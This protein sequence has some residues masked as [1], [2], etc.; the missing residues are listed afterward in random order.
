MNPDNANQVK[1]AVDLAVS[2]LLERDKYL[3]ITDVNERSLT[4]KLAEYLQLEF[5]EWNVDCE[6]NR[7]HETA[8]VLHFVGPE[9]R[10]DDT[11]ARTVFPDVIIHQRGTDNNLL[12]IE[13]KK[14]TN[15]DRDD[16]DLA[17][18]QAFRGE[19]GYRYAVFL[20]FEAAVDEPRLVRSDWL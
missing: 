2:R 9:T 16:Q 15:R 13:V 11:N 7:N 10:T 20:K 1:G 14:S 3:L 8:K 5:A 12:V 4:H 18:L 19:L 6:Y 17:K